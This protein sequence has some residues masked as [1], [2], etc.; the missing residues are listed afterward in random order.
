[1]RQIRTDV[2]L[3]RTRRRTVTVLPPSDCFRVEQIRIT[4]TTADAREYGLLMYHAV[5]TWAVLEISL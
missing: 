3:C 4:V 5:I 2:H 1:M